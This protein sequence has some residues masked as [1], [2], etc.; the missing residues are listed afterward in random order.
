MK[1]QHWKEMIPVDRYV[2]RSNGIL[3]E[4]DRKILTMLYQPLVGTTCFGLYMTLWSELEQDRLW[5]KEST[6]HHLMS[7]MQINLKVIYHERLKLEGIGLLKTYIKEEDDVRVFIYELIPPLTPHQFFNDGVLNVYLYN[8]LG[9]SI[10]QK[11]KNY[12]SDSLV[13][14][15]SFKDVTHSFNDVFK[16]VKATELA[17]SFQSESKDVFSPDAQTDFVDSSKRASIEMSPDSFDFDLFLAGLTDSMISKRSITPKVKQAI[18]KL[19]FLYGIDPL[20]MKNVVL[21]SLNEN[22]QVDIELLRKAA[23]S[24]YQFENGEALPNLSEQIQPPMLRTMQEKQPQ[25]KEEQLIQQLEVTS[26]RQ[27]LIEF[28][29]GAEPSKADL[30]MIEEVMFNQKLSPGVVNVLIYYVML[31]SDMKLSKSYVEKIAGHWARKKVQTVQDAMNLAKNEQKEYQNWT[32]AKQ[33]KKTAG[34]K[35][36]RKEMVPEW[37]SD[38]EKEEKKQPS[39]EVDGFEEEKRKLQE[40]LK[41]LDQELKQKHKE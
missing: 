27:L 2:V 30:Q 1:E 38:E 20:Q 39:K 17:P 34:R 3:Q 37:L 23:Q 11:V 29:G 18:E 24:F 33:N 8:R 15:Q 5:G 21:D 36:V 4:Y 25:T 7:M 13:D 9:K 35:I 22:D 16:S 6:H 26:P 14:D 19:A 31:R 10:F 28:S 12:F 40:E 32:E 41:Q